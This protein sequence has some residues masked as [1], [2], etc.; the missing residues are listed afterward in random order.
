MGASDYREVTPGITESSP[1]RVHI[2]LAACYFAVGSP[3]PGCAVATKGVGVHTL[4]GIVSWV[5]N[6]ARQFV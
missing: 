6:V 3:Y 1:A 5:K 4:K 2:D